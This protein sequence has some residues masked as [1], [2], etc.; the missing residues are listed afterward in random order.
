MRMRYKYKIIHIQKHHGGKG[1]DDRLKVG[2]R[3]RLTFGGLM[4]SQK[5]TPKSL[6]LNFMKH[7]AGFHNLLLQFQK[8]KSIL[9][10]SELYTAHLKER[11]F[12][13]SV[14]FA[15]TQKEIEIMKGV[16]E[17]KKGKDHKERL[18]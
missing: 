12:Q 10:I 14:I 8:Q 2:L 13:K 9:V 3:H 4:I 11:K 1:F 17:L 6:F 7:K 15:V 18:K 16:F 5:T